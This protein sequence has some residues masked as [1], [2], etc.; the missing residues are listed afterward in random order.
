MPVWTAAGGVAA[1]ATSQNY[2]GQVYIIGDGLQ[3]GHFRIKHVTIDGEDKMAFQKS[4]IAIVDPLTIDDQVWVTM[5]LMDLDETKIAGTVTGGL[6]SFALGEQHIMHSGAENIF[7]TN[8]SSRIHWSPTWT[9]I[10]DQFADGGANQSKPAIAPSA[11]TY[12]AEATWTALSGAVS[13]P[14][15]SLP[16]AVSED[17]PG[18]GSV[19]GVRWIIMDDLLAD[20]EIIYRIHESDVNGNLIYAQTLKLDAPVTSGSL[21][22][23]QYTH[24]YEL[25]GG[26]TVFV[27]A[28]VRGTNR[29]LRP[30]L[31]AQNHDGTKRWVEILGRGF[32]DSPIQLA[33]R[34]E[35]LQDDNVTLEF[36]KEYVFYQTSDDVQWYNGP[37]VTS[38]ADHGR[39]MR[40]TKHVAS[41]TVADV[42]IQFK[43]VAFDAFGNV[44][45]V[46]VGSQDVILNRATDDWEFSLRVVGGFG[47][48]HYYDRRTGKGGMIS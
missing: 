6:N 46:G 29:A 24:P 11:R 36:D 7:F 5:T 30:L 32:E 45:S 28:V 15:V 39:I 4:M 17:V 10:P 37:V 31:V 25:H 35:H 9:G 22:E 40:F 16:Y 18:N 19:Y 41:D 38:A 13:D 27:D 20:E 26:Q 3:A 33:G 44:S 8:E 48:W 34:R 47:N 43:S 23:F 42:R 2:S 21:F 1:D 12:S 14:L